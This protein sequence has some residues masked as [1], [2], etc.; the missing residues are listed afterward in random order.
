MPKSTSDTSSTQSKP[1]SN[2]GK[3]HWEGFQAYACPGQEKCKRCQKKAEKKEEEKEG[4]A[5]EGVTRAE[6]IKYAKKGQQV[7]KKRRSLSVSFG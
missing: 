2:K 1:K 5:E 6:H 7:R 3:T 4:E